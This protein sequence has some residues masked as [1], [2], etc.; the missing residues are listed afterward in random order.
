MGTVS[1][2]FFMKVVHGFYSIIRYKI[3]T[4]YTHRNM[5]LATTQQNLSGQI[6]L[7]DSRT[8]KNAAKA[9]PESTMKHDASA[10]SI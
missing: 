10:S 9:K 4:M 5:L 3:Y 2:Y 8:Q 1:D 6:S 7:Q